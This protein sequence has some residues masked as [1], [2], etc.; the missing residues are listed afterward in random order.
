MTVKTRRVYNPAIESEKKAER[1]GEKIDEGKLSEFVTR[2]EG[3][4]KR[5]RN[6]ECEKEESAK[7]P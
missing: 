5:E 2:Q 7:Y 6:N 1:I 3:G 4:F